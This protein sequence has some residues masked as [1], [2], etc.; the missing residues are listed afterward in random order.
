[1]TIKLTDDL[2]EALR[3]SDGTVELQ[4]DQSRKV[5]VLIENAV[6]RRAMQAL[7]VQ[8]DRAAIQAGIRAMEAGEVVTLEEVDSRIRSRLA[9]LQPGA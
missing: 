1:M 8:E 4:D 2:R 6:F 5:D 3:Q 7:Q 9:S